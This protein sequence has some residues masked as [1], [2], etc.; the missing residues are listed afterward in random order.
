MDP[1][2]LKLR[3]EDAAVL[4]I[5][6]QERLVAAMG[7]E[8]G[9]GVVRATRM[10]VE[11]ARV[12]GLPVIAT[13]QYPRGLGPTVDAVRSALPPDCPPIEKT[14]FS[15]LASDEVRAA[16]DATGRRQWIVAGM[17]AHVCVYQTVRD[18]AAAGNDVF[19]A[20]DAVLSRTDANVQV[21]LGLA[22]EACAVAT[23]VEAVLFDLL[24]H[25]AGPEFKAISALVKQGDGR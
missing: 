1:D 11:G 25:A 20:S 12:L 22:R 24:G 9:D 10:L 8:R 7:P 17:E 23:C 13:E 4:V 18:L 5:D 21:G 6:V 14:S 2:R 19:V 3:R 16:I 15:C